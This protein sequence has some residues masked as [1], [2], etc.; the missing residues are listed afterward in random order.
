MNKM[1]N[2]LCSLHTTFWLLA[3]LSFFLLCGFIYANT[4]FKFYVTLDNSPILQ[5]LQ[6]AIIVDF[7]RTWW[8]LGLCIIIPCIICN[9]FF[10][11]IEKLILIIKNNNTLSNKQLV[12]KYI[13]AI[14][15]L[16]SIVILISHFISLQFSTICTFT[17][18]KEK[19]IQFYS[20]KMCLKTIQIQYYP[21]NSTWKNTIKDISITL[22][23]SSDSKKEI[24][25]SAL[26]PALY[27][28]HL[29]FL[30]P[31]KKNNQLIV[32]TSNS[33]MNSAITSR[34][35]ILIKKDYGYTLWI[36]SFLFIIVFMLIFY[37]F[38]FNKHNYK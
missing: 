37:F 30:I 20:E 18:N 10:C 24:V 29:F 35:S 22:L 1:W 3:M 4:Y 38:N 27:K 36:Y 21:I 14:V 8:I 34:Y 9:M 12:G 16:M 28:G 5:W 2:I 7:Y 13:I 26:N 32:D 19:C 15:H 17:I 6:N 25:F 11:T 31:N 23:P 33:G